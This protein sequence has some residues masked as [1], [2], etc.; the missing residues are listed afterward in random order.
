[1]SGAIRR[2]QPRAACRT[3]REAGRLRSTVG[4]GRRRAAT[5]GGGRVTLTRMVGTLAPC[6]ASHDAVHRGAQQGF[7]CA[8]CPGVTH[9]VQ[10]SARKSDCC[11]STKGMS[12]PPDSAGEMLGDASCNAMSTARR[13]YHVHPREGAHTMATLGMAPYTYEVAEPWAQL[14]D[15]WAFREVAGRGRCAGLR[16]CL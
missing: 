4:L 7:A 5:A 13:T 2:R 16:L 14:P 12:H 8:G 10:R 9:V 1:M 6:T 15:G 11:H 3:G